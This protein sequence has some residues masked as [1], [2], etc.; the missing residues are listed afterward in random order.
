M[1]NEVMSNEVMSNEVKICASLRSAVLICHL[2][3]TSTCN[4]SLNLSL[5]LAPSP[6]LPLFP[7]A[8]FLIC[9]YCHQPSGW[10]LNLTRHRRLS[11]SPVLSVGQEGGLA[12]ATF[13]I[14]GDSGRRC[15]EK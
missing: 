9:V 13:A 1:R 14:L 3:S 15:R 6:L 4:L 11:T 10:S 7:F 5:S 8:L 2:Q 12:G